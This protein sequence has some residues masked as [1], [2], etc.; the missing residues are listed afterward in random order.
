MFSIGHIVLYY[1]SKYCNISIYC[2]TPSTYVHTVNDEKLAGLKF[3]ECANKSVWWKKV[4]QIYPELQ[5]CMD[6]RLICVIGE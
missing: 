3:G 2:F 6:I 5:V 4:W 1:N